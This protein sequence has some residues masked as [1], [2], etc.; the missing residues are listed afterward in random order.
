MVTWLEGKGTRS[1]VPWRWRAWYSSCIAATQTGDSRASLSVRGLVWRREDETVRQ[2]GC[3]ALDLVSIGWALE[4]GTGEEG[5]EDGG[6]EGRDISIEIEYIGIAVEVGVEQRG[7]DWLEELEIVGDTKF[8]GLEEIGL[9]WL[10]ICPEGEGE[11][12][13]AEEE[14]TIGEE[15]AHNVITIHFITTRCWRRRCN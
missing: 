5:K 14:E 7:I 2:R 8:E 4:I 15:D 3:L 9:E 12:I 13:W 6:C 1:Q 10:G 11:E